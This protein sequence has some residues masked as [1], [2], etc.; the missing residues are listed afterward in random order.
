LKN[1]EKQPSFMSGI[2]VGSAVP[3]DETIGL[4]ILRDV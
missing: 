4:S 3:F 2:P 1:S